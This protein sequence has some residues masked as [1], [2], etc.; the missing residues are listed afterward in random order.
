MGRFAVVRDCTEVLQL[1][2]R[3]AYQGM[4]CACV[5]TNLDVTLPGRYLV[6]LAS[7]IV[8]VSRPPCRLYF[9]IRGVHIISSFLA[10][11]Q[12]AH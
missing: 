12:F 1:G 3:N 6:S 11:R 7:S 10:S 8:A 4:P 9:A 5:N 2:Q